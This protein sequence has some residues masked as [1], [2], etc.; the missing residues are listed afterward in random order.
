[1]EDF[2]LLALVFVLG[3]RHG[4]DADH[5]A[6]IDG[7]TRY[8]LRQGRKTARWVGTLFS[9]G[10]GFVVATVGVIL[11]MF[12]KE[13]TFPDYFDTLV[14]WVSVCS[15]ALIGVL[16]TINL[17]RT[18]RGEGGDFKL[19]GIKGKFIPKV[20][21]E[22][23]NP[24]MIILVGGVFAL[25]ADTVS[26]TSVWALASG[27]ADNGYLPILLGLTFMAGM[28]LTDTI[29]SLVAYRMLTQSGKLGRTA[30]QAMGWVIVVLA[31][32][33]SFY[34]AF[35]YFN[36]WAELDFEVVGIVI[37]LL[38]LLTF[39]GVRYLSRNQKSAAV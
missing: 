35:T 2:S 32:G 36:P 10:H 21:R 24:F 7:L 5:L 12:S 29:D 38:L 31:F 18:R 30:S 22:T 11:A 26:Q 6:C 25:A 8:N 15:L 9:F 39:G 1:M 19:R 20:A 14:T 28:M 23:T 17:L 3:L 13:F 34:E 37:F 4:L 33:V 27:N 16:N